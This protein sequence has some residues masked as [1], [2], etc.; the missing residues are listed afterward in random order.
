MRRDLLIWLVD[1]GLAISFILVA[2]TGVI[3]FPGLPQVIGMR[4]KDLPISELSML[5][6]WSGIALI[7]LVLIH[8][9]LN[10]NWI[11]VT[12]KRYLIG[13]KN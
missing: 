11:V 8:L 12:T 10:W 7:V 13:K 1:L 3:K 4:Y 2:I 9:I 5:H 6:D